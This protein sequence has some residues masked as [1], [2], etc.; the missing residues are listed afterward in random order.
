MPERARGFMLND[1]NEV[2]K[3]QAVFSAGLYEAAGE[4]GKGRRCQGHFEKPERLPG[5]MSPY[6]ARQGYVC[7]GHRDECK[8]CW[9]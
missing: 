3:R 2:R 9:N 8:L 5:S 7:G 1:W 4:L 6:R